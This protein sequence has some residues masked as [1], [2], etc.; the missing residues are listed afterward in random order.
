MTGAA[1]PHILS[2]PTITAIPLPIVE[3]VFGLTAATARERY[4]RLTSRERQVAAL[5]AAGKPNRVIAAELGITVK[6]LDIHRGHIHAKVHTRTA[7]GVANVVNLVRLAEGT[8]Q[9]RPTG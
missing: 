9:I 2:D 6:T 4:T 1:L 5:M 8:T 3:K 7:A